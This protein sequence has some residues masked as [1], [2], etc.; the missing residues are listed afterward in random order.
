[1]LDRV[2]GA[3]RGGRH[4]CSAVV[5]IRRTSIE[6]AAGLA[7]GA[8]VPGRPRVPG[9]EPSSPG[10]DARDHAVA[11]LAGIIGAPP[12]SEGQAQTR[13]R[14]VTR[15]YADLFVAMLVNIVR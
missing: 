5:Q 15:W 7:R 4:R 11:L 6:P 9:S 8:L 1:M 10:G 13:P 2:T 12:A 3:A 14:T